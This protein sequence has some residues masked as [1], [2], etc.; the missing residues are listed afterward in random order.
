MVLAACGAAQA[1]APGFYF[2]GKLGGA[3]TE[4]VVPHGIGPGP[5]V[6]GTNDYQRNTGNFRRA[7]TWTPAAG[8]N[9]LANTPSSGTSSGAYAL[10]ADGSVLVG[11]LGIAPGALGTNPQVFRRV[12]GGP[13]EI[14]PLAAGMVYPQV[15]GISA[16]GTITVGYVNGY[17]GGGQAVTWTGTNTAEV[18]PNLPGSPACQALGISAD[19]TVVVGWSGRGYPFDNTPVRWVNGQIESLGLP[20]ECN[21]AWAYAASADGS[22]VV[23]LGWVSGGSSR[24][25]KWTAE[26]GMTLLDDGPNNFAEATSISDDGRTIGGR[27]YTESAIWRDGVPHSVPGELIPPGTIVAPITA[28]TATVIISHDGKVVAGCDRGI[29]V[30]GDV[31]YYAWAVVL[32]ESLGCTAPAIVQQPVSGPACSAATTTLTVDAS[33]SAPLTFQWRH[34]SIPIDVT[35]NP[36]AAT[37]TLSLLHAGA[38]DAGDYDCIITNSCGSITSDAASVAVCIANCDCSA[39]APM[40]TANDFQ[41]FLNK[42][43]LGDLYANCDQSTSAPVLTANDFQCFLN[44]FASGCN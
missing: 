33:G 11:V 17:G 14:L 36:S 5:T 4:I 3:G 42:F 8:I 13:D 7:F 22:V 18:L 19:G 21:W 37:A 28:L 35:A 23:G 30:G 9:A 44:A 32:P 27:I 16:A 24:A 43:A 29:P 2:I 20:P 31:E 41:C 10:S 6:I 38:P 39:A 40:L 12:N 15:R 34:D 1:Q 26:T 25:W